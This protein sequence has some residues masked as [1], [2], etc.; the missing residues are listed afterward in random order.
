MKKLWEGRFSKTPEQWIEEFGVSI[1]FDKVF[2][3]EDIEGSLA[4]VK[5]LGTTGIIS[6]EESEEIYSG[7]FKLKT[8]AENDELFFSTDEDTHLDLEKCL[9]KK[10]VQ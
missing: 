7:L 4:H 5:M 6:K 10:S 1:T 3:R 8:R 9:S 2:E